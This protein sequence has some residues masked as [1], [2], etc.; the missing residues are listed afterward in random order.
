MGLPPGWV[1]DVPGISRNGQLRLIG[2]GV[3]LLQGAAAVADL[4]PGHLWP[5]TI[6]PSEG[7]AA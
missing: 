5:Y 7:N 6:R 1:T 3:V 2:N 4:L